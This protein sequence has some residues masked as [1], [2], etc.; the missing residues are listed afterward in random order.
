[1]LKLKAL[2]AK[3]LQN[4]KELIRKTPYTV[5][6]SN[7]ISFPANVLFPGNT[8]K[9]LWTGA[10]FMNDQQTINLPE[11]ISKQNNGIVL[12]WSAYHDN[13]AQNWDF[14]YFF[15]PKNHVSL[16]NGCG[17]FCNMSAWQASCSKYVYVAD[18][19]IRGHATNSQ[20]VFTG[21]DGLKRTNT[22]WVLR[23]VFGV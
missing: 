5:D 21:S 14:F 8:P 13:A 22:S 16:W 3:I 2:L 12:C 19:Y 20:G 11:K 15:I 6:G 23:K 1:M 10:N 17:V 4:I 18:T 9:T 7:N